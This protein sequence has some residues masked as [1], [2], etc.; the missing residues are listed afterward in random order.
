MNDLVLLQ[1]LKSIEQLDGEP[2]YQVV[3]KPIEVIHLQKLKEVHAQELKRNAQMLPEYYVVVHMDYVHDVI[4]VILFQEVKNLQLDPSL[5]LV[6]F[7]VLHNLH[8]NLFLRLMIKA[9]QC[10]SKGAFAEE[11][12]DFISIAYVIHQS[13]L[14]VTFVIIISEIA[15]IF[16][17]TLNL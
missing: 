10:C 16:G 5:I 12:E 17:C 13:H 7:L 4:R 14:V 2:P 1:V 11:F 9:F 8:S 15:F 6:L 3:V